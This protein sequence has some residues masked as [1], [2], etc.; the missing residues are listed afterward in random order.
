MEGK[1]TK[2]GK[3]GKRSFL[4]LSL[5]IMG[6]ILCIAISILIGLKFPMIR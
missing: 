1:E 5:I 3:T 6:I 2:N 4:K